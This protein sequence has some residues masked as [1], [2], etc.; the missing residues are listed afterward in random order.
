M[1]TRTSIGK[2]FIAGVFPG[3]L[4]TAILVTVISIR[5]RLNPKLGP[6]GPK[7]TLKEKIVSVKNVWAVALLV[8]VCIGGLYGGIFTPTEAGA[9]GAFGALVISLVRRRLTFK[10][11]SNSVVGALVLTSSMFF[12][13]IFANSFIGFLALTRIPNDLADGIIALG[14]SRYAILACIVLIYIVLGC[15]MNTTPAIILSLPIFFPIA[16]AFGFDPVWFGILVVVLSGLGQITPPIGMAVF[17]MSAIAKDVPM[18]AIFKGVMPFYL[19]YLLL[20]VV[21]IAFPQ[22]SLFLPSFMG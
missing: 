12:I 3:I 14:L 6:P 11:F 21:L 17:A 13:F 2:L 15:I 9:I 5:C 7:T 10:T 8:A 4:L 20:M 16:M 19:A 1:I 22:I 18:Y